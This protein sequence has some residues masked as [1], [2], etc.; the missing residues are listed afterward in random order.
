[1]KRWRCRRSHGRFGIREML[2]VIVGFAIIFGVLWL[3]N[4]QSVMP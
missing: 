4:V 2:C 1:V 3:L